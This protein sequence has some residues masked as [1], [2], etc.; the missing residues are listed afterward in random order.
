MQNITIFHNVRFTL[1]AHLS[2][3]LGFLFS[4]KGNIILIGNGLGP[5]KTAL[6]ITMDHSGGLGG[7]GATLYRPSSRANYDQPQDRTR[8]SFRLKPV[9]PR[10]RSLPT[11][12]PACLQPGLTLSQ[13]LGNNNI[14]YYLLFQVI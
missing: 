7:V 11:S 8:S 4:L 5:D 6:K 14:W 13:R 12:A 1:N 10:C 2:G 9:W 3:F